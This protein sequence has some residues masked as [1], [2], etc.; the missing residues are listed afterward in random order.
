MKCFEGKKTQLVDVS[1]V[2]METINLN[3]ICDITY[4]PELTL[5]IEDVKDLIRPANLCLLTLHK[6]GAY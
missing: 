2:L 3:N 6:F 4:L 1:I 5:D